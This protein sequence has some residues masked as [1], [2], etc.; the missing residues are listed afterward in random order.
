MIKELNQIVQ[1]QRNRSGIYIKSF[2]I[3]RD[4]NESFYSVKDKNER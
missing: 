4:E 2:Y 1:Q 3:V